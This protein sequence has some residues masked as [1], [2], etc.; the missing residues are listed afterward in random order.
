MDVHILIH[1]Y[2]ILADA[3]HKQRLEIKREVVSKERE[4]EK[5]TRCRAAHAVKRRVIDTVDRCIKRVRCVIGERRENGSEERR[6]RR[7]PL[8][9]SKF[10]TRDYLSAS[11]E[12]IVL[13]GFVVEILTDCIFVTR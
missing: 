3:V 7:A 9:A 6:A 4:R 12:R 13:A 11:N 10:L 1:M 2:Y 8:S 5:R